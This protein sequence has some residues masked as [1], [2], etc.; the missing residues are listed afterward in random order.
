MAEGDV[1]VQSPLPED[2]WKV[3]AILST[4]EAGQI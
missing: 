1:E 3:L 4:I 2:L